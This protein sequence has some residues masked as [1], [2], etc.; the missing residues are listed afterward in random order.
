LGDPKLPTVVI[1]YS[2][3]A[4]IAV[5]YAAFEASGGHEPRAVLAVFP[6]VNAP[7][8]VLGPLDELDA[9]LRR[10]PHLATQGD[11]GCKERVLETRRPV[12]RLG[13]LSRR[14][15]TCAGVARDESCRRGWRTG[16]EP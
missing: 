2:R 14:R 8:E 10:Q 16:L 13:A 6:A 11:R 15:L 1:G 7:F 12:D 3:G 5:D 4:R 9:G